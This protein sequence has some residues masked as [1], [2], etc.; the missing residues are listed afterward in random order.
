MTLSKR[1]I[2]L[3]ELKAELAAVRAELERTND[4]VVA[5]ARTQVSMQRDIRSI[6]RDLADLKDR[7]TVLTVAVDEHPPAHV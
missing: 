2:L 4:N 6:Q 7:V 3:D 5:I 1:L